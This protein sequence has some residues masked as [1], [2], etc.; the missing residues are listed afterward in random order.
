MKAMEKHSRR[1]GVT[2]IEL[3]IVMVILAILSGIVIISIG[4][5]IARGH[6]NAYD[7]DREQVEMAV[8]DYMTRTA[9]TAGEVPLQDPGEAPLVEGVN[10]MRGDLVA[11]DRS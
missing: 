2:L 6:A 4:G 8:C 9:P 7:A 3:L 11:G 5:T 1:K 10:I